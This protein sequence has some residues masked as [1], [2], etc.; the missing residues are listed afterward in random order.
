MHKSGQ[1]STNLPCLQRNLGGAHPHL[2]NIIIQK[3]GGTS[4]TFNYAV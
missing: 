4:G 2:N 3:L 1:I